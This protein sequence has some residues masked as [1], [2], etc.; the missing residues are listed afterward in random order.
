LEKTQARAEKHRREKKAEEAIPFAER[1][2]TRVAEELGRR[3]L[4][5]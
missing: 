5:A 2:E 4:Q 1:V 3:G